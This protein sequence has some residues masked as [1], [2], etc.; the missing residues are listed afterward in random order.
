MLRSVGATAHP[1]G[2]RLAAK[3]PVT[4]SKYIGKPSKIYR[5][6]AYPHKFNVFRR[7][8]D[9]VRG[10][11]GDVQFST[12]A[13]KELGF[14]SRGLEG[15]LCKGFVFAVL[16]FISDGG[17]DS[18]KRILD[19]PFEADGTMTAV[20]KNFF[21]SSCALQRVYQDELSII[22]R[23]NSAHVRDYAQV[24][25]E[26]EETIYLSSGNVLSLQDLSRKAPGY[27][28][29]RFKSDRAGDE[30]CMGLYIGASSLARPGF[31]SYRFQSRIKA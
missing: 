5:M 28:E 3:D 25:L 29:L 26:G 8:A 1:E 11:G 7:V 20:F 27:Y 22:L 30:H 6:A 12:A 16:K 24:N 9:P 2:G 10:C 14:I 19:R 17:V 4:G 15:G 23:T 21:D 31:C 13:L 18:L